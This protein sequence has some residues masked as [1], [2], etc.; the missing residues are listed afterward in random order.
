MLMK[1]IFFSFV[2]AKIRIDKVTYLSVIGDLWLLV[3][4]VDISCKLRHTYS[5]VTFLLILEIPENMA[6]T[7]C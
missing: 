2:S 4:N 6:K 5:Y 3:C 1:D 7:V